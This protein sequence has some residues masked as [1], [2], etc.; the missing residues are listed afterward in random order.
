MI[1][2]T[3]RITAAFFTAQLMLFAS[4]N[5]NFTFRN[6]SFLECISR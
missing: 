6:Y 5:T 1:H 4:R 2:L 3:E